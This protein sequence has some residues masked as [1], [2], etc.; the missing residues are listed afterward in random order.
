MKGAERSEDGR[1]LA[2]SSWDAFQSEHKGL[3]WLQEKMSHQYSLRGLFEEEEEHRASWASS[4]SAATQTLAR[5]EMQR[6]H[7]MQIM[8]ALRVPKEGQEA[9]RRA[10]AG[11]F[12]ERLADHSSPA[13]LG[14]PTR[15][16]NHNAAGPL[17]Q[18]GYQD[19]RYAANFSALPGGRA[20]LG[21]NE[22][23]MGSASHAWNSNTSWSMTQAGLHDMRY[24]ANF[25]TLQWG[26][27]SLGC[28]EGFMGS[29]LHAWNSNTSGPMT[30]AG[31]PD[32]RFKCNLE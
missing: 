5:A 26:R 30:Q 20:S 32:M 3:G 7:Q 16:W 6:A 18:A 27:L 25:S 4:G 29:A 15:L 17:T 1:G 19:M 12:P 31:R 23:F 13:F 8:E 21:G 22:G 28:H 11:S 14:S 2:S 24:A 9:R 10:A